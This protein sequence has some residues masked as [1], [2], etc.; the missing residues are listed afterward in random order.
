MYRR[1]FLAGAAVAYRRGIGRSLV[2]ARSCPQPG[3]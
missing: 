1:T 3:R 2:G